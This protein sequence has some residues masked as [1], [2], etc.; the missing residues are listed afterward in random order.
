MT[1]MSPDP[2]L[3]LRQLMVEII[4]AHT[5]ATR[6]VTGLSA[7]EPRVLDAMLEVPRHEFVP[8]EIRPY[9]HSDGPLPIGWDKTISQPFI[10]ALMT[11]LLD[12]QPQHTVLEVGT[13]LGYHTAVLSRLAAQVYTVEIVEELAEQAAERLK[14]QGC[15][16][17]MRRIGNGYNGWPEH[18]PYDR[19]MV[20]AAPELIPPALIAQLKPGGLMV[21]PAGLNDAQQLMV[22]TK[23]PSGKLKTREVLA[24]RFA[25]MEGTEGTM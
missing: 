18:A 10:A 8:A 11:E 7:I 15:T 24:V 14:V 6:E 12:V 21:L 19:I 3:P 2:Y 4:T 1:R 22:V 9:A 13:G 17:V 16:N 20:A 23:E 5:H 25:P